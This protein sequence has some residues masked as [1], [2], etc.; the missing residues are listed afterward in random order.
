[1]EFDYS[2]E[3]HGNKDDKTGYVQAEP[4]QDKPLQKKVSFVGNSGVKFGKYRLRNPDGTFKLDKYGK[5]QWKDFEINI[6]D[7]RAMAD[8]A[9]GLGDLK[10]KIERSGSSAQIAVAGYKAED[11]NTLMTGVRYGGD[12]KCMNDWGGTALPAP[13]P[14]TTVDDYYSILKNNATHTKSDD[15]DS[16]DN[17]MKI[18]V[19]KD[20]AP[21]KFTVTVWVNNQPTYQ[22]SGIVMAI[23]FP[24]LQSHWG[25]GVVYSNLQFTKK[26]AL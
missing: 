1:M 2:F 9:G 16:K 10:S 8:R 7:V 23:G 5:Q 24:H 17:H 21:N 25:S 6:L 26:V 14:P 22:E 15:A 19:V 18:E 11:V 20:N 13:N 3:I 4:E 12:Y